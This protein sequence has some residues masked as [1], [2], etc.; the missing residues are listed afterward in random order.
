MRGAAIRRALARLTRNKKG[1]AA[2]EFAFV[3][4]VYLLLFFSVMDM[5]WLMFKQVTLDRAVSLAARCAA[6]RKS[7]CLDD[8]GI[9]SAAAASA[10]VLKIPASSFTVTSPQPSCGIQVQISLVHNFFYRGGG[11]GSVTLR[12]SAC[13]ARTD[14]KPA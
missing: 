4:P 8:A 14:V 13:M 12:S 11:L 1:V 6:V 5:G 3:L 10:S 9:K 2:I 7:G